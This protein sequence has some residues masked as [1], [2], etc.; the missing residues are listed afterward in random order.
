MPS[1]SDGRL[2]TR[3]SRSLGGAVTTLS[4]GIHGLPRQAGT[5]VVRSQDVPPGRPSGRLAAAAWQ[6][7]ELQ[8]FEE[9]LWLPVPEPLLLPLPV[10]PLWLF[11]EPL[12]LPDFPEPLLL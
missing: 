4:S 1:G 12:W 11:E 3:S 9:P 7:V 10:L 2:K 6:S 8:H 5:A